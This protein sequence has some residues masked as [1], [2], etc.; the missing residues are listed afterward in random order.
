MDSTRN[1]T[2]FVEP[3]LALR[4]STPRNPALD[5]RRLKKWEKDITDAAKRDFAHEFGL[6]LEQ[7]AI[8]VAVSKGSV[9]VTL[10]VVIGTVWLFLTKNET[11]RKGAISFSKDISNAWKRIARSIKRIISRDLPKTRITF[12]EQ[13]LGVVERLDKLVDERL[14]GR[15]SERQFQMDALE[16]IDAIC[17]TVSEPIKETSLA[18]YLALK[19]PPVG[20]DLLTLREALQRGTKADMLNLS[21]SL[22]DTKLY[23]SVAENLDRAL[24]EFVEAPNSDSAMYA[25]MA[26]KRFY[27]AII[28]LT[29]RD[30][31]TAYR[32]LQALLPAYTRLTKARWEMSEKGIAYFE[33]IIEHDKLLQRLS[34][35]LRTS[36]GEYEYVYV[37]T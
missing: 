4:L 33:S 19:N 9:E 34:E 22:H 12:R 30:P 7:I 16:C 18:S 5:S 8:R 37:T 21:A 20:V 10:A 1:P 25:D 28:D 23:Q 32:T 3:G 17:Q 6:D 29:R 13:R 31:A 36:G 27:H 24:R 2:D 14:A 35:D 11:G 26:S 15:L